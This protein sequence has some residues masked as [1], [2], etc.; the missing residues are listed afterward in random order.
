MKKKYIY[1]SIFTIM[2]LLLVFVLIWRSNE[3]QHWAKMYLGVGTT[4]SPRPVDLNN[5]GILDIVL[6]G[7]GAEYDSTKYAVLAI[8]GADGEILWQ[9][10]G[11][12]QMTGSAIFKDINSDGTPEV[13]IGGRSSQLMAI[14]GKSGEVIWNFL[15]NTG[16]ALDLQFDTT[17]LNFY[18]P[19]FIP[20]QNN[21][22]REDILISFGGYVIAGPENYNRPAGKLMVLDIMDGSVITEMF[23]PDN[24]ETYMSPVVHDF[25]GDG[26]LSVIFGSGGETI[27]GNLYMI[28]LDDLMKNNVANAIH[29]DSGNGK[30]FI[31][32]P[33]LIDITEDK[34]KDI[35]VNSMNGR[36]IAIDGKSLEKIWETGFGKRAETEAM[37]APGFFDNDNIPDF[38]GHYGLGE[39]PVIDTVIH[40]FV[41]GKTGEEI[42]RD[43]L[44][45]LQFS[46]PVTFD[47]NNDGSDDVL[48][49]VNLYEGDNFSRRF[50][51]Q[52]YVYDLANKNVYPLS[53]INKGA[54]LGTTPLIADLDNDNKVDLVICYV[55]EVFAF[56]HLV[57]ERIELNISVKENN[58]GGY[59]GNDFSGVYPEK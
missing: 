7:A 33:L 59:M 40:V 44:G 17:L 51:N 46:S 10:K 42:F 56:K 48:Q 28:Q 24:K 11:L 50:V 36:M 55:T 25:N 9:V 5:D 30:G 54:N 31:A 2:V 13:F 37:V 27:N 39:W 29:L 12:N 57:V 6:G 16:V 52:L 23:M 41:S 26:N 53:E 38:F 3:R 47:F 32:P 49:H 4:S 18:N 35:I 8:N 58:W 21:D 14:D 15:K 22:G 19:Q 34:V 20:D 1:Y 43:T 45:V